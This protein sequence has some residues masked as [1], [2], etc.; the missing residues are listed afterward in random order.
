MHWLINSFLLISDLAAFLS[1]VSNKS[2]GIR[3]EI[4][5]LSCFSILK[6]EYDNKTQDAYIRKGTRGIMKK[7]RWIAVVLAF[8]FVVVPMQVNADDMPTVADVTEPEATEPTDEPK[9]EKSFFEK[10][11]AIIVHYWG[12]VA[13]WFEGVVNNV[14]DNMEAE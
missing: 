2:D 4:T 6:N 12:V 7:M 14:Y 5:S 3:I 1:T 13:E 9:E 10:L 11:W 8:L